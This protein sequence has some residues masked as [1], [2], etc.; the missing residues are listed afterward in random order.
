M[1]LMRPKVTLGVCVKNSEATIKKAM[2]SI[3]NQDFP[4][5][6]MELIVVDG[7]SRDKTIS[8]VKENLSKTDIVNKIFYENKGLGFAR[9]L[10][11]NDAWG[12]YIIWVD[13]DII[14]P[15]DYVRK[16]VEFMEQN[17]NVG[18]AG[19]KYG[20]LPEVDFVAT[21][22][23]IAYVV[24]GFKN[25]GRADSKGPGAGGSI[26]RTE[27]IRQVKGFDKQIRGAGEDVDA[28]CRVRAAGWLL[29]RTQ[30]V[31]YERCRQTWKAHW[32]QYFSWGY[33]GH[34]I[35]RKNQN[36]FPLYQM[37]PIVAFVTSLLRL[38]IAYRL[39]HRKAVLF[40]PLQ[41]IFKMTAWCFG[42]AKSHIDGYGHVYD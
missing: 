32:N 26:Y 29:Y 9:Q 33:G 35:F 19:G 30:A 25:R 2:E 14:L 34:F 11:V 37:M 42:F 24:K 8:F 22:E 10:V 7:Y 17:P 18:I 20:M 1:P 16:Q 28:A 21:L 23:N 6:L 3:I 5:E 13:G 15:R 38:P 39:T 12:D 41:C 27:A 4:H 31:F 40:W 36:I